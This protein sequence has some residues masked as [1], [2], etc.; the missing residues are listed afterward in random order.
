LYISR[1]CCIGLCGSL[2]HYPTFD[3]AGAFA[4]KLNNKK[5][6]LLRGVKQLQNLNF[7]AMPTEITKKEASGITILSIRG[8]MS[9][10]DA[11]ILRRL[12]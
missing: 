2:S 1:R 11:I 4:R 7:Q 3:S 5:Q 12:V 8:E 10:D 6:I 9:I